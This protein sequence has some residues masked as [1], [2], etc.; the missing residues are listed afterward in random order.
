MF[1]LN[2]GIR[3][4]RAEGTF[5]NVPLTTYPPGTVPLTAP[6]LAAADERG[7]AL[8]LS[9]SAPCSSRRRNTCFYVALRQC[10]YARLRRRCGSAA[11]WSPRRAPPIPAPRR[12]RPRAATRSAPRPICSTAACSSPP[13]CSA[14]SAAISACRQTTPPSRRRFRWSTAV[15]GSTGSRSAPAATSRR[16]GRSSPITPISTAKFCRAFPISASPI[17]APPACN[18]AAIPDPQRG[19]ACIQTPEPFGQPVHHLS[20]AV[21]PADRLRPHLSGQASPPISAPC[22]S[23]RNISRDD[24]LIHRFFLSYEIREGLTAQLNVTNVTDERY[25]TGVRNNVNATTGRGHRRLGDA[26]RRPL[27][28]AEPVLQ[29]LDGLG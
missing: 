21:R 23:G 20:A 2:G 28:G 4:E 14:T 27:G 15:R 3:L 13:P 10:P 5:R 6:Q 12:P 29:F 8:L 26:R 1:E 18:S 7:D 25:F 9:R 24:C 17:R 16:T 19:D 11:A 22:S